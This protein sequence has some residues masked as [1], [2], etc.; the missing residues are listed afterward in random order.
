[1]SSKLAHSVNKEKIAFTFTSMNPPTIS[2]QAL[3][4]NLKQFADLNLSDYLIFTTQT[5]DAYHPLPFSYKKQVYQ[6]VFPEYEGH[7]VFDKSIKTLFDVIRSLGEKYTTI[8]FIV[9]EERFSLFAQLMQKYSPQVTVHK[10]ICQPV[11][12]SLDEMHHAI[13][14][15]D[16]DRF[17][18]S[19]PYPPSIFHKVKA[20][21]KLPKSFKNTSP[22]IKEMF[23]MIT[24]HSVEDTKEYPVEDTKE[25]S[26]KPSV[27]SEPER[28]V[29][30]TR[31]KTRELEA[32]KK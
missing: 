9:P 17:A 19:S 13:D 16:F 12:K 25:L 5:H 18:Q 21:G 4:H 26:I 22:Y 10:S 29:Y 30:M 3:L 2:H 31:S 11:F 23:S 20:T 14:H 15:S 7:F 27:K 32:A 28:R 24:G 8:D 6:K 1:M